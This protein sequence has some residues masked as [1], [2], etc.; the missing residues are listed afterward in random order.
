MS[1]PS[2]G[3]VWAN[4]RRVLKLAMILR[5]VARLARGVVIRCPQSARIRGRATRMFE[6]PAP[7]KSAAAD[8]RSSHL[9]PKIRLEDIVFWLA[10]WRARNPP[11]LDRID[12]L[13]FRRQSRRGGAA[14]FRSP[15][16]LTRSGGSHR[17]AN[18]IAVLNPH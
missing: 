18:P 14:P 17:L 9:N 5:S 16:A 1:P 2:I 4:G 15:F 8:F 10:R 3:A 6:T 7:S 11:R 13:A 12:I